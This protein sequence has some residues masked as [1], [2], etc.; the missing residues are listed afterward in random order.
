MAVEWSVLRRASIRCV[1]AAFLVHLALLGF[2]T[3]DLRAQSERSGGEAPPAGETDTAEPDELPFEYVSGPAKVR[4]GDQAEIE[5]PADS[6]FVDKADVSAFLE[7]TG[8]L[9]S[10][11]YLGVVGKKDLSWWASF[12]FDRVGRVED[13][14]KEALDADL[15]LQTIRESQAR[16][17]EKRRSLGMEELVIEKWVTKP[18]YDTATNN[19]EWSMLVVGSDESRSVNHNT[20]F[21]GRHGV[22]EVGLVASEDNLGETLVSFSEVTSRFSYVDTNR[23]ADWVPGDKVAEYGLT[24]LVVGGVAAA[25]AKGGFFKSFWKL[26]V[27]A[28]LG[29]AGFVKRLIFGRKAEEPAEPIAPS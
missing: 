8:N 10:D 28:A 29:L 27:V 15:M 12:S 17:N 25:A 14:E 24:A 1:S 22:M 21:L 4:L 16:A 2:W 3:A 11:S 6:F 23:Y 9:P 13:G 5:I 7:W 20:R 18:H 26:L 19:L